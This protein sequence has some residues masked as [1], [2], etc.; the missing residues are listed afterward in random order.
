MIA[1]DRGLVGIAL[2]IHVIINMYITAQGVLMII[3]N[4]MVQMTAVSLIVY[5]M[6]KICMSMKN[7]V[8]EMEERKN[9]RGKRKK[10]LKKERRN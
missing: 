10:K 6:R 2:K 7:Y 9:G 8:F 1:G 5:C 4:I 3:I